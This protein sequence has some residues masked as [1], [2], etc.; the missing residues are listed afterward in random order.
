MPYRRRA[1]AIL[2]CALVCAPAGLTGT[3]LPGGTT[4]AQE[5]IRHG[6]PDVS[7]AH[8]R[9]PHS[10][11][12]VIDTNFD[13]RSDVEELYEN[14]VLVRR[15]SDRNFDDQIDLVQDFDPATRQIV[16]S[17]ADVNDDGVAD[18]LVLFQ[19]GQPVFSKWTAAISW[20]ARRD[21]AALEWAWHQTLAPLVDPFSGDTAYKPLRIDATSDDAYWLPGPLDLPEAESESVAL[22]RSARASTSEWH[23][24]A[25]THF[26]SSDLRGPPSSRPDFS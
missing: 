17:I 1:L 20:V 15:A 5:L 26:A 7:R 11:S 14:G 8:P 25:L 21:T 13:G 12:V 3:W 10:S 18:L 2:L 19:N 24:P 22:V 9:D 4:Q 6:R 16:R 23:V